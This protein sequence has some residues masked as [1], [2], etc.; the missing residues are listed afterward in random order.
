VGDVAAAEGVLADA[1]RIAE[2][3]RDPYDLAHVCLVAAAMRAVEGDHAAAAEAAEEARRHAQSAGARGYEHLAM[4]VCG[5]ALA[6]SGQ[7]QR[8]LE[9]AEE[10]AERVRDR[11]DVERAEHI[12]RSVARTFELAGEAARAHAA[13]E[14]ARAVVEGRLSRI[15]D[16]RLRR[17]YLDK[18]L[19]RDI[20]EAMP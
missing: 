12:H 11:T 14:R 17:S 19:V 7:V 3:I 10:V 13:L 8:G 18:R 5:E 20:R 6:E 15:R 4:A 1:R 16:E 2:R 9:L